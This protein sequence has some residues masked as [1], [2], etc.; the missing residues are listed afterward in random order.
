MTKLNDKAKEIRKEGES[1]IDAK[2]RAAK[3]LK[4][5]TPTESKPTRTKG[6]LPKKTTPSKTTRKKTGALPKKVKLTPNPK[7]TKRGKSADGKR[8][9]LPAGKRVSST[10]KVY[11]EYRENKADATKGRPRGKMFKKGGVI[12]T[13]KKIS[14]L[15]AKK[16]FEK[17]NVYTFRSLLETR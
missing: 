16:E 10:G 5:E 17:G 15:E 8:Q 2:R 4:G 14:R 1:Y 11:Y 13:P 9:A 12:D 6:S 3:I 7:E